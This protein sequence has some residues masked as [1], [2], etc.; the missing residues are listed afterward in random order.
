VVQQSFDSGSM[1]VW[2]CQRVAQWWFDGGSVMGIGPGGDSMVN[3]EWLDGGPRMARWWS[4]DGSVL[5]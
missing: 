4:G 1:V 5:V 2:Y 3:H